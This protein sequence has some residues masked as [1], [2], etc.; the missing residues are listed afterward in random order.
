M[1]ILYS[2][3]D[4]IG[5]A[6]QLARFASRVR[7]DLRIAAHASAHQIVGTIDWCLDA[8]CGRNSYRKP[9]SNELFGRPGAPF[10]DPDVLAMM[11][12]DVIAWQPDLIIS[13]GEPIVAHL[14]VTLET[15]LWYSSPLHLLD[16]AEWSFSRA[17]YSSQLKKARRYVRSMPRA[18]R[19]LVCSPFI[20]HVKLREGFSWVKPYINEPRQFRCPD[21]ERA[22]HPGLQLLEKRLPEGV[23]FSTGE[24]SHV[25]DVLF[26]SQHV[27]VSPSMHDPETL[28]NAIF[29][30]EHGCG[31]DLGEVD[32]ER[33][34]L[35]CLDE[36]IQ[37]TP[38]SFCEDGPYLH[39]LL[40]N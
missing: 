6:L 3:G 22:V 19:S 39:E 28:L 13:D 14:A 24:T 7:H 8:L 15:T 17:P 31:I 37:V 10:V 35:R 23:H 2:A 21:T 29:C 27:H 30:R 16:G 36:I 38:S 25:A 18:D 40:E 4:R 32:D 5:A 11:M 1:K 26:A 20:G 33:Y 9:E 12:D 34:A